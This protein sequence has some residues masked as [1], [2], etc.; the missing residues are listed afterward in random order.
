MATGSICIVGD[1]AFQIGGF[2]LLRS[3]KKSL[4]DM[5]WSKTFK[6]WLASLVLGRMWYMGMTHW[7][8]P[9]KHFGTL[10]NGLSTEFSD[11]NAMIYH[12][13]KIISPAYRS[14]HHW[15][16]MMVFPKSMCFWTIIKQTVNGKHMIFH[17]NKHCRNWWCLKNTLS[18]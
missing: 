17:I 8:W 18:Q 4:T 11:T 13:N 5:E 1:S 3:T 6:K 10:W 12:C 7:A 9:H 15:D 2:P 16:M 14:H